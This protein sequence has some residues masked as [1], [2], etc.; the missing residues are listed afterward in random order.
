VAINA[1]RAKFKKPVIL[2]GDFNAKP[3]SPTIQELEKSW[4]RLTLLQP[5]A[6]TKKPD[7]CIDYIFLSGA[8]VVEN[9]AA[10]VDAPNG[11][12]HLPITATV[13]FK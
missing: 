13:K 6:P 10:V 8:E 7:A 2:G 12:D 1:E 5:T 3:D 4:K 9:K 11:S